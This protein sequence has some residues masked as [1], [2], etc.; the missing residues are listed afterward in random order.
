[1]SAMWRLLGLVLF[2]VACGPS[3]AGN[4]ASEVD[5]PVNREGTTTVVQTV[6]SQAESWWTEQD[7]IAVVEDALKE[8]MQE[9]GSRH[10]HQLDSFEGKYVGAAEDCFFITDGSAMQAF[11]GWGDLVRRVMIRSMLER[12]DWSVIYEPENKRWHVTGERQFEI[13][14]LTTVTISFYV[15]ERTGLV[16]GI[17]PG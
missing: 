11:S 7:A 8:E 1:M 13:P 6:A 14:D 2:V 5:G 4:Q 15:Y 16:E 17:E 12:S 9:C 10:R 3:A